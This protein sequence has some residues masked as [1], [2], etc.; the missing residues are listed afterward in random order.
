MTKAP[1]LISIV[2]AL[3]CVLFILAPYLAHFG[4]K[5]H[6]GIIYI[7][8]SKICHQQADRSFFIYGKQ[9][10]VCSRCTAIYLGFFVGTL[11]QMALSMTKKHLHPS[12]ILL[13]LAMIP[14]SA[15]LSLTF[16]GI[17]E[18][19]FFTRFITGTI[20]G[21]IVSF[22]IVPGLE[23]IFMEFLKK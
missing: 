20:L 16:F 7:F 19:T 12:R 3:W 23:N 14:I 5:T 2:V 18:N 13:L 22:Y 8:F 6:S 15:D 9:L 11:L 1:L 4:F 17:W 21:S 10:A